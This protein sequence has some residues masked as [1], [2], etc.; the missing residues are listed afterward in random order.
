[1]RSRATPII[2]LSVGTVALAVALCAVPEAPRDIC[3][4]V[5]HWFLWGVHTPPP[6]SNAAYFSVPLDDDAPTAVS[7]TIRYENGHRGTDAC[8]ELPLRRIEVELGALWVCIEDAGRSPVRGSHT[9]VRPGE[10]TLVASIGGYFDAGEPQTIRHRYYRFKEGEPVELELPFAIEIEPSDEDSKPG[11]FRLEVGEMSAGGVQKWNDLDN[12][13]E[14]MFGN[15]EE[16]RVGG[17]M[18]HG[19]EGTRYGRISLGGLRAGAVQ[20]GDRPIWRLRV[21]DGNVI[22]E[23]VAT[24]MMACP[25]VATPTYSA[26]AM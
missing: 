26:Q 7:G 19:R 23:A 16:V 8:P 10:T 3:S 1:M 12:L 13:W 20:G 6:P 9:M 22:C 25:A 24:G 18:V 2:A 4:R 21:S 14:P 15:L 5:H 17:E 11:R